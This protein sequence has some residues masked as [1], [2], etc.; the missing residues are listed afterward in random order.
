MGELRFDSEFEE[1]WLHINGFRPQ[2]E[3]FTESG[4]YAE[5]WVEDDPRFELYF[6]ERNDWLR[7]TPPP[8]RTWRFQEGG[9]SRHLILMASSVVVC[10]N[11]MPL[12]ITPETLLIDECDRAHFLSFLCS[13][14]LKYDNEPKWFLMNLP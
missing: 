4:D 7:T 2:F 6:D 13:H 12:A 10:T 8:A 9:K 5:G 11:R 14:S 3:P 1:W